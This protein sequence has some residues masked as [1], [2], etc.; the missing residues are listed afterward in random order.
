MAFDRQK[1]IAFRENEALGEVC[2]P[3]DFRSGNGQIS[4]DSTVM[5]PHTETQL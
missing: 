2:G 1:Q 3:S 4:R 5:K